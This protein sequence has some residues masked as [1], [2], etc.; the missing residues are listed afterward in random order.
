V[1]PPSLPVTRVTAFVLDF[2]SKVSRTFK[3]EVS[4]IKQLRYSKPKM[5]GQKCP[6][7]KFSCRDVRNPKFGVR[8]SPRILTKDP[9]QKRNTGSAVSPRPHKT[10]LVFSTR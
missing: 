5:L 9:Q 7:W 3:T 2:K 4:Y 8:V 1:S 10:G 6:R